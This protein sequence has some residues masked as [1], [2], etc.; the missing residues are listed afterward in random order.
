[1]YCVM[2]YPIFGKPRDI[3]DDTPSDFGKHVRA[4]GA[5]LAHVNDRDSALA[6]VRQYRQLTSPSLTPE[7]TETGGD[8]FQDPIETH[9][10]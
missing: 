5:L 9:L 10:A 1:M 3:A 2:V 7:E 4:L 8:P 6:Q